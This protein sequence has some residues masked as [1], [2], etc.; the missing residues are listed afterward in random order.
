MSHTEA[1]S[2]V[3]HFESEL[4]RR[5]IINRILYLDRGLA[6]GL[7][8]DIC[9]VGPNLDDLVRY[10]LFKDKKYQQLEA[11]GRRSFKY[12]QEAEH[13]RKTI[14]LIIQDLHEE[15]GIFY[16]CGIWTLKVSTTDD[17]RKAGRHPRSD[18]RH[19]KK[20]KK[21]DQRP[22][23]GRPGRDRRRLPQFVAA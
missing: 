2:N 17:H 15:G 10:V 20:R 14:T 7:N 16:L 11:K 4:V 13:R 5:E 6:R 1:S 21:F 9:N 22:Y 8:H 12:A 23:H 19:S 18:T 3:F